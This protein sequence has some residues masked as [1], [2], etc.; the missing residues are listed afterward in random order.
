MTFFLEKEKV[1][2]AFFLE[3]SETQGNYAKKVKKMQI[4]A[5]YAQNMQIK[6]KYAKSVKNVKYAKKVYLHKSP[7]PTHH[8]TG[9]MS[10]ITV[11]SP[12][13]RRIY[14]KAFKLNYFTQ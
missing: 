5:K 2:K 11:N 7:R 10:L 9:P 12:N 3:R 4:K 13:S 1:K 14:V 8:Q 6:A